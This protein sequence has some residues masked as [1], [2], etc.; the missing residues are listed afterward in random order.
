MNVQTT[1]E[2][3]GR[4]EEALDFY[5]QSLDAKILF[6]LRFKDAHNA[7][8]FPEAMQQKIL[9]ATFKVGAT[10]LM[11]SDMGC[12]EREVRQSGVAGFCLALRVQT[13]EK[14]ERFFAAL[15]ENGDVRLPLQST[16]FAERYG[17]VV[18]PFGIVWKIIWDPS[19]DDA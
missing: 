1:L 8:P 2:F 19:C 10:E 7:G 13:L 18:D 17:V 16:F 9:H 14:A 3:Y 6:L 12:Q 15:G 11:A 5:Q 4:T